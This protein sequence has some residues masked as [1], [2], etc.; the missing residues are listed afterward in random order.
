MDSLV[1]AKA[2][3]LGYSTFKI[4]AVSQTKK[5]GKVLSCLPSHF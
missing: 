3:T 1:R 2:R 4:L 5:P